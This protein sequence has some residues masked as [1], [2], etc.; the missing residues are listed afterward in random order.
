V[1]T[2]IVLGGLSRQS[3]NLRILQHVNFCIY[4]ASQ[5]SRR[6]LTNNIVLFQL[7]KALFDVQTLNYGAAD[8]FVKVVGFS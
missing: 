6:K 3:G 8:I 4:S 5:F 2:D 1:L 7:K